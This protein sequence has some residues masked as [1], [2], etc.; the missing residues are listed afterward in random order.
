MRLRNSHI[1]AVGKPISFDYDGERISALEGESIAA[2]LAGAGR[3]VYRETRAGERRGLYC[4]MGHCF[5]C[6]VSVD[7]KEAQRACM[8][9]AAHGMRVEVLRMSHTDTC[10]YVPLAPAPEGGEP[11]EVALDVLVVGAGPAG[12]SAA[13][14]ARSR[15]ASVEV[16]DE[17]PMAGGQFF[18]QLAPSQQANRL[19]RQFHEGAALIRR[20]LA[21]GVVLTPEA[22]VWGAFGPHEIGAIVNGASVVFR[23]RQIVLASGAYEYTAPFPGWTLPG[24]MT[25][26]GAQTLA[27]AYRVAPGERIVIAGNGPLNLQLAAEL[28]AGGAN[29][30]AVLD[31]AARPGLRSWRD[32]LATTRAAPGLMRDGAAYLAKLRA[33]GVQVVWEACELNAHGKHRLEAISYRC[34]D[35]TVT[36]ACDTLCVGYGFA[37]TTD[38]ARVLGCAHSFV[39]KGVGYLAT[40]VDEN[41]QTSVEGVFAAGDGARVGGAR[42]A[43]AR[44]TLAGL[45]AADALGLET[46]DAADRLRASARRALARAERFQTALWNIF[47]A[48]VPRI[49]DLPPDT[50]VCRCEDVTNGAIL[51][52]L[53]AGHDTLAAIKRSTRLGMGRCQGRNCVASCAKLVEEATGRPREV[54]HFPAP[55]VPVRP[56]PLAALA[57]EK[58]EWGGHRK[59]STPNLAR[60]VKEPVLGDQTADVLVIGGGVMGACLAHALSRA[61]RDVL[62]VDR[63]DL[64][65]QASGA[66]AG[67]L[68]VQLLSFDFGKKARAGGAPAANTLALGPASVRLWQELEAACGESL[69]IR[70]TGGLMVADSEAGMRFLEQKSALE[71]QFG[72]E[73]EL[74]DTRGLLALSPQ[75]SPTL[76]GAEYCPMEG[77]INPLRATYTVMRAAIAQG[78][79]FQRATNVTAIVRD[80]A[81]FS[82][83][84]SRGRI[85]ARI[86][87]NAAGAWAKEIGAMVGVHVPVAGAPLQMIATEPAPPV[88]DHLIAHADRHL[89]LKQTSS[90]GLLIGGGWPAAFDPARRMNHA[91]RESIEGNVWAASRVLPALNGLHMVRAWAG[92]NI[93]IDGAPIF[94]P[95]KGTEGFFNAVTSNGYTLAP[96]VSRLLTDLILQRSPELDVTPFLI[97]RFASA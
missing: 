59:A 75:L 71:R 9:K 94:G 2:A 49:S 61:G 82:V 10:T 55:R 34:G 11:R 27:R 60:P 36:V 23:P 35:R 91:M 70:V 88:V 80:R 14:A 44:G 8:T 42:V 46:H 97:D 38:I 58:A 18:K 1:T 52:Q 12:L 16:I 41:G 79:R 89:S 29:V 95:V 86:V 47:A 53:A 63:D 33:S 19:D 81:G 68:H 84:T 20:A 57:F 13:C 93:D 78:A 37:P 76:L 77:K 87:V 83:D 39:D 45:A 40:D 67:S 85:R 69:E 30:V 96:I 64:N 66:N 62:V 73:T 28:V 22:F 48:P 26:G 43:L 54:M 50:V 7:G 3:G 31:S 17:R 4:G 56:V 15:G 24:V 74:L 51:E 6:L 32:L 5:E 25:T 72:I 21:M 92:M 90:G 65:L